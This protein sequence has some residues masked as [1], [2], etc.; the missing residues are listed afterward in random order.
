MSPDVRNHV[1]YVANLVIAAAFA[2]HASHGNPVMW[3][4]AA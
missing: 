3:G 2:F 4:S 1:T